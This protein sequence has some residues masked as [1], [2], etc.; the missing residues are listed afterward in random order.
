MSDNKEIGTGLPESDDEKS[1]AGICPNCGSEIPE[2][3]PGGICPKCALIEAAAPPESG[4]IPMSGPGFV[5]P[6]LEKIAG[7][8][9]QLEII[10]L[11][12]CGGMGAVYKA[13]Q[14]NLDR[15]VA[16]KILPPSLAESPAFTERFSREGRL[17]AKLSH[18]NIVGVYDF[19]ESGG[20]Y[21]LMMEFVDGVNLRQAMRAG[22]FTPEQAIEIVPEVCEALQFAHD[23]GVLHRDIK[24]ENILLDAKGRVKIADFGIAKLVGE[25][26]AADV[27]LTGTMM[28]GTPQYMAPEQIEHPNIVDH[29]ADI[30]SLGVVFYE[31]LTGELPMG[32]F[33]APSEKTA[34]DSQ[35]D[36]IVFRSLEKERDRRQ[37]SASQVRTE[38]EGV[39]VETLA[40]IRH[41]GYEIPVAGQGPDIPSGGNRAAW[42]VGTGVVLL[43]LFCITLLFAN[44]AGAMQMRQEATRASRIVKEA[45]L[46]KDLLQTRVAELQ[47]QIRKNPDSPESDKARKELSEL[48]TEIEQMADRHTVVAPTVVLTPVAPFIVTGL[49]FFCV[50]LPGTIMGW[51]SLR[52]I[53]AL[54]LSEGKGSALFAALFLPLLFLS[55]LFVGFSGLILNRAP[56]WIGILIAA[57][58]LPVWVAS[59]GIAIWR[60]RKWLDSPAT[61]QERALALEIV[62]RPV[63]PWPLQI[64]WLLI[65]AIL[66]SLPLLFTARIGTTLGF[67]EL[68]IIG[69]ILA[70][71]AGL[72]TALFRR[73]TSKETPANYNPWPKRVFWLIIILFVIPPVLGAIGLVI[74]YFAFRDTN[75]GN[76]TVE[77]QNLE[78]VDNV[79]R[80]NIYTHLYGE[81][82]VV[83]RFRYT[84]PAFSV[85]GSPW[86]NSLIPG[87]S[88]EWR[89]TRTNADHYER[90]TLAFPDKRRANMAVRWIQATGKPPGKANRDITY[91]KFFDVAAERGSWR[92][93]LD[94]KSDPSPGAGKLK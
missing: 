67:F 5:P 20:F 1:V 16:L 83:F 39:S 45:A 48:N 73:G 40:K 69:G 7:A 46:K 9:P 91:I 43:L 10:E 63:N 36:E 38:I 72:L 6:S 15:Y 59:L 92:A 68:L 24:P 55:G 64:L 44:Q 13:R 41:P 54:G 80:F 2:E 30:Y 34:V 66:V 12:G 33:A 53:R 27:A 87:D 56:D 61:E 78:Q 4:T 58:V 89:I 75:L 76:Y 37:Q 81:D 52:R 51:R 23:E 82:D 35:I 26:A 57:I 88:T 11:V 19:G 42:V 90:I 14:P 77:V 94:A 47:N 71:F 21:F 32:R 60:T 84:G 93:W 3:A 50:C 74:P 28:P 31:M 18:P 70:G 86:Q 8:F 22:R 29:R 79:V 62:S 49:I 17:L 25:G 65:V 85:E